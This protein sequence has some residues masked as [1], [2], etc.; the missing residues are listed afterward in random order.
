MLLQQASS[1]PVTQPL[2]QN[3]NHH[4]LIPYRHH[5]RHTY[6]FTTAT[7]TSAY[8]SPYTTQPCVTCVDYQLGGDMG[9]RGLLVVVVI[10][11]L[12]LPNNPLHTKSFP[13]SPPN[14]SLS[15]STSRGISMTVAF[16]SFLPDLF[17]DTRSAR[18]C[19]DGFRLSL[20][21]LRWVRMAGKVK[22]GLVRWIVF[23]WVHLDLAMMILA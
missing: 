10:V 22:S 3:H 21:V 12:L 4:R 20:V 2:D 7:T 19:W 16:S 8:S 1:A 13:L 14:P 11:V 5:N 18:Q 15:T 23:A 9:A 17:L 6:Q